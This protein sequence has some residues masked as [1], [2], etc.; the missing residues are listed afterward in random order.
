M[1]RIVSSA[2]GSLMLLGEHAVLRGHACLVAAINRRVSVTISTREDGMVNIASALG[3][4][5]TP[6]RET[7]DHPSFRF[8]LACLRYVPHAF[9]NGCDIEIQADM[10]ATIGFGTSAAVTVA[11][12]AALSGE[13]DKARLMR[14]ARAIIQQVQ[15]RGSGADVAASVYGGVVRYRMQNDAAELIS[16]DPHPVAALYCGYKTPTPE[17][18]AR[19]NERWRDDPQGRDAIFSRMGELADQGIDHSFGERLNEGQ[20]LMMSLGVS[21]PELDQCVEILRASPGIS[22]AKISGSGL[23]DCAIGWG[24]LDEDIALPETFSAY[25]LNVEPMGVRFE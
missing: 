12:L 21:T 4:F 23:G 20:T 15:G 14:E 5:S 3:S 16:R 8:V 2:P 11:V 7:G 10:P 24:E 19:V 13:T 18:I 17:V 9:S 22:G 25:N 1:T 6:R